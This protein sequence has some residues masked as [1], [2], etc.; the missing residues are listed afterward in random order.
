MLYTVKCNIH[1]Y[2]I[3]ARRYVVVAG[4]CALGS[5]ILRTG[6]IRAPH[7][8][9]RG[10][11]STMDAMRRRTTHMVRSDVDERN[12]TPHAMHAAHRDTL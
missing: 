4:S 1:Q 11:H 5:C 9:E 3:L 2:S 6:Q 7:G 8:A 12:H 10:L